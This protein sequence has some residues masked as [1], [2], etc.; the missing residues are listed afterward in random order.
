MLHF[1]MWENLLLNI[2]VHNMRTKKK[3]IFLFANMLIYLCN[4]IARMHCAET[5]LN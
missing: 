1:I 2:F 3:K 5:E 4:N